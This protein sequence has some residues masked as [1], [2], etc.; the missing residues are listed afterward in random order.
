MLDTSKNSK[1]NN[2]NNQGFSSITQ[3]KGFG[4]KPIG[5][6]LLNKLKKSICKIQYKI[7]G[8]DNFGTGFFMIYNNNKFLLTC[9]HVINSKESDINIEF[10]NKNINKLDLTNRNIIFLQDPI[11]ITIIEINESDTFIYLI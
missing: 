1:C 4:H 9:Y 3:E 10:W 8:I 6:D 5:I 11:D 2:Q 7:N